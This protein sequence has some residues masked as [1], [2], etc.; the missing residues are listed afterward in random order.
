MKVKIEFDL[1]EENQDLKRCLSA[2]DLCSVI[3]ELDQWLRSQVKYH[4]REDFQEA[5]DH[6]YELMDQ[7]DINLDSIYQ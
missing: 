2:T 4:G 1:P 5:R 7:N 3:F 6:L